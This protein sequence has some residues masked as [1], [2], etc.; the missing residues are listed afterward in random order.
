M[1][2][3]DVER[4]SDR[5]KSAITTDKLISKWLNSKDSSIRVLVGN[6]EFGDAAAAQREN[7]VKYR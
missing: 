3:F 2:V 7:A 4:Q 5:G 6:H 1:M